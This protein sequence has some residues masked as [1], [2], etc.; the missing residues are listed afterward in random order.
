MSNF[1]G[2]IEERTRD[3]GSFLVG[4][5]L[6]FRKKRMVGPF[7]FIDHMGPTQIDPSK[8][9]EVDQHPHIGISTLTYLI[10][11]SILH[12]DSL[13]SLQQ[14]DPGAVNLMISG[15]GIA[16]AERTPESLKGKSYAM[17]GYQLWIALPIE[18]EGMDPEFHHLPADEVPSW[19]EGGLKFRLIIGDG[20]GRSSS[21]PSTSPMFFIEVIAEQ[22]STLRLNGQVDGE[23]G[24]L[25]N[26]GSII[27]DEEEIAAGNMLVS[28]E[29][30]C[31]ITIQKGS[32]VFVLGGEPF[33]EKR[34]M[35]W[36]FVSS[37]L[38]TIREAKQEWAD[39]QFPKIPGDDS[40]IPLPEPRAGNIKL[41]Q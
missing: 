8:N 38:E 35:D 1:S 40:Y 24:I 10:E 34:Y 6:P 17:H 25:V 37:D 39:R 3:L 11:G 29:T 7:A 30:T 20:F 22:D 13:G 23:I 36:N 2:I 28:K 16:H 31:K 12:S 9:L 4:R 15:K 26:A 33:P 21:L 18:K 32:R 41:K 14:I 27:A 19:E 5:I